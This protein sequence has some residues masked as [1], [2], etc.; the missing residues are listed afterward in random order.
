MQLYQFVASHD[1]AESSC[2]LLSMIEYLSA[3]RRE[4]AEQYPDIADALNA[5]TYAAYVW[6]DQ[7][8]RRITDDI[9]IV[10]EFANM[11]IH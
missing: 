1:T 11:V 9:D 10:G 2:L 4:T 5:R 8:S 6:Y 7:Y 3:R